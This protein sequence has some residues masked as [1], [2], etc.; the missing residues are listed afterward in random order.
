[1]ATGEARIGEARYSSF[2]HPTLHNGANCEGQPAFVWHASTSVGHVAWSERSIPF[3]VRMPP[4]T[5]N[6]DTVS[7]EMTSFFMTVSFD[8]RKQQN[9]RHLIEPKYPAFPLFTS[10]R[11]R[12]CARP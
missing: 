11:A 9:A 5:R 4:R 12:P 7:F 10:G 3:P 1:L 6:D 8:R 2:L